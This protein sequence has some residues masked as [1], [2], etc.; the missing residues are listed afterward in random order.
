MTMMIV[1]F[2]SLIA[3]ILLRLEG[4][5]DPVQGICWAPGGR[6][7]HI[8][9]L[10]GALI[11]ND[12][13]L[14]NPRRRLHLPSSSLAYLNTQQHPYLTVTTKHSFQTQYNTPIQQPLPLQLLVHA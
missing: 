5:L 11:L 1:I 4:L 14:E 2:R 8:V 6:L 10:L 7:E 9:C 12:T 13:V 3:C